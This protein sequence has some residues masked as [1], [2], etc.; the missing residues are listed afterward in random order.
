[1]GSRY[2]RN[3]STLSI[4]ENEKLKDFNICI[5]GCGGLGG[6]VIEMLARLGIGSITAVDKDAFDETNLNRQLLS[7]EAGIGKKKVIAAKERVKEINSNVRITTIDTIFCKENASNILN[8]HHVVI[9]ALDNMEGRRVLADA[10]EALKIPMIHGAIAG[11]YGQVSTILPGEG[12]ISKIYPEEENKGIE[13]ELGNPSFTPAL[14]ASIQV[15]ETLKILFNK[16]DLLNN[17]LLTINLLNH[18][19]DI[20]DL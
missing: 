12:T 9:D 11:W 17:R 16:G 14:I 20:F 1:M 7:T 15:A 19:Y 10:C 3:M 5:I 18:E 6:Y 4:E 13:V 8:G 2:E